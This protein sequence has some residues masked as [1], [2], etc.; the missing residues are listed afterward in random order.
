[1]DAM[2]YTETQ[3][4]LEKVMKQVCEDYSP[5][6]ITRKSESPVVILSLEDYR[7]MEETAYLLYSPTNTRHLLELVVKPKLIG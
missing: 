7:A 5:I 3:A 6:I 4:N 2:Y 1:M